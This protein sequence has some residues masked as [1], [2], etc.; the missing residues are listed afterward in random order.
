MG[1]SSSMN[2]ASNISPKHTLL[3]QK[4]EL[5]KEKTIP[6]SVRF[7]ENNRIIWLCEESSNM[8]EN[9][10]EQFQK[11]VYGL[12]RFNNVD[13]CLTFITNIQDEKVFLIIC[14]IHRPVECFYHLSQLEKIYIIGSSSNKFNHEKTPTIQHISI[15]NI[16]SLYRQLQEDIELSEM[17]FTLIDTVPVSLQE[18]SFSSHLIKQ[19][20]SFLFTQMGKEI[21]YRLKLESGSKDVLIDFCRTHYI[22][23]DEQLRMIDDF[24]KNYRPNKALRWLINQCFISRILNRVLRTRELDIVYK[25]GFFL[26]Q[27]GLQLHRLYE[28]NASL[29]KQISIVYRGKTLSSNEF[30]SLIKNNCGGLLSFPNFLITTINKDVSIDF[31]HRRLATHPDMIGIIFEI[32]INDTV[33]DKKNPFGLLKD[34]DMNRDE[35]CFHISSVFRMESMEQITTNR[36]II[37]SVKLK[38]INDND[39]QLLRLVASVR[40]DELLAN[41]VSYLGKLLIDMGEHRCA[42]QI[43][44]ELLQDVSIRS[45]PQRLVRAHKGLGG[46]Y[47]YK[48]EYTTALYHFQQELQTSLIYLQ[49]NHPNLVSIYRK[50][51]DCY[52]KQCDYIHAI[53]HYE[54]AIELLEYD[55]QKVNSETITDLYNRISD[56]KQSVRNDN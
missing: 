6:Q 51:G 16:N 43:F 48:N 46:L 30:D 14:G 37:W 41:P 22:D 55:T 32:H 47:L 4:Q 49:P 19:E 42:E 10:A 36:M 7:L 56:A 5:S 11:R 12:K 35:V 31:V 38:L 34:I 21:C 54:K 45:Q 24:A 1:C 26:R 8:F 44:L 9:E 3:D 40:I 17:D 15:V 18:V 25:L 2:T 52:L 27:T 13:T 39:E 50:L 20:A 33:A 53:E 29:M 28:D 23:T